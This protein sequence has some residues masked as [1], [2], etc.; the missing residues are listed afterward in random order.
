MEKTTGMESRSSGFSLRIALDYF[1]VLA[2]LVA[3]AASILR[4]TA[5]Y[6]HEHHF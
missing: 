3:P 5:G 6:F 2:H 4:E 1:N